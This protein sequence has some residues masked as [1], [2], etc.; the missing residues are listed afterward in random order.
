LQSRWLPKVER[1]SYYAPG[2]NPV[3]G[4]QSG[5]LDRILDLPAE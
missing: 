5:L 4:V 3:D 2:N 1:N